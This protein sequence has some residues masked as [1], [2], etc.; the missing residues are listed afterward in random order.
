MNPDPIPPKADKSVAGSSKR[1]APGMGGALEMVSQ[2]MFTTYKV[3]SVHK[4]LDEIGRY[5]NHLFPADPHETKQNND[6]VQHEE[7]GQKPRQITSHQLFK[8]IQIF[9][10]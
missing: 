7:N 1:S 10:P 6:D 3:R 4:C 9:L 8:P 5:V 2:E